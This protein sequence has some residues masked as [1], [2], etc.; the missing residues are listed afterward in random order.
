MRRRAV[1]LLCSMLLGAVLTGGLLTITGQ[2]AERM[3]AQDSTEL[4]AWWSLTYEAPN[5]DR[6][7][8]QVRFQ[9]LKGLE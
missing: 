1:I 7:P 9:W 8:V 5:P 3:E 2:S 4:Y 6:L